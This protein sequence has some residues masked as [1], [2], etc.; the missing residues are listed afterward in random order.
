MKKINLIFFTV[1]FCSGCASIVSKSSW[2]VTI[3]S[4]P[5]NAKFLLINEK[6]ETIQNGI[7]PATINLNSSSGY[8]DGATYYIK[9][10]QEGSKDKYSVIDST[11]N[12]WYWGNILFGGIIGFMIFDPATGAMWKLP[13]YINDQP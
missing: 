8:F 11:I 2:P 13:K 10:T 12:E 9:F 4:N 6:G 5:S 1:F 3:T 7:T